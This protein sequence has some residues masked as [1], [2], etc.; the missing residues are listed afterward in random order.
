MSLASF[1]G[2]NQYRSDATQFIDQLK[3]TVRS[4]N[5]SSRSYLTAVNNH[6]VDVQADFGAPDRCPQKPYV[7]QTE[8]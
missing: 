2:L 1:F 5:A 4:S 3:T 6:T 7:Y 8:S